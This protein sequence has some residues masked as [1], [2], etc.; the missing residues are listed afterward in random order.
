MI[1]IFAISEEFYV[2]IITSV[3]CETALE[4]KVELVK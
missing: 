1:L 2:Y 4:R 3:A